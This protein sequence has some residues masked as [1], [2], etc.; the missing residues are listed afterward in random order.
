MTSSGRRRR[1][2]TPSPPSWPR[3][4]SSPRWWCS[5]LTPPA[6]D[7]RSRRWRLDPS[8]GRTLH[9]AP[10]PD[11]EIARRAAADGID[12]PAAV[13]AIV[14]VA[15]GSPGAASREAAA[16][17][18][19][20]AG[21]RLNQAAAV[22]ASALAAADGARDSVVE[23]V[24]RLVHARAWGVISWRARRGSAAS[25]TEGCRPT[26]RMDADVFVGRERLVAELATR[27]LDRRVVIVTGASGSGKSS[28]AV[29]RADP[30]GAERS[31]ARR[32]ALWRVN[33]AVPGEDPLRALDV[34]ADLDET[35][36]A[37]DRRR[38]VRGDVRQHARRRRPAGRPPS[39]S[40]PGPRPRRPHRARGTG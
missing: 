39:R 31:V 8:G 17:A 19:Q 18:E 5:S 6:A 20:V 33:V 1:R 12:D 25:P 40:R 23:E 13:A 14:S 10:L 4:N 11:E 24:A 9:V 28:L 29:G 22:S 34:L 35:W 38:P 27:V 32:Q 30:A 7:R 15:G 26:D 16:W 21:E 36:G 3:S 37:T 2:W